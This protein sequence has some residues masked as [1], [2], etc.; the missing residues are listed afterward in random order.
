MVDKMR[1]IDRSL[2]GDRP[3]TTLTTEE[4]TTVERSLKAV[5]GMF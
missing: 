1:A 2:F 4:M 5:L 3:L